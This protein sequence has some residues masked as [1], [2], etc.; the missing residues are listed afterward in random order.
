MFGT[1]KYDKV[2]KFDFSKW[3][4]TKFYHYT[5][6]VGD[7]LYE[8]DPTWHQKPVGDK[9]LEEMYDHFQLVVD[10]YFRNYTKHEWN[11]LGNQN[12]TVIEIQNIDTGEVLYIGRY[13]G[14]YHLGKSVRSEF[15]RFDTFGILRK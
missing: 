4:V 11:S 13:D 6:W 1:S 12:K 15:N 8:Y 5:S 7:R 2:K 10:T 3:V 9:Y 14:V